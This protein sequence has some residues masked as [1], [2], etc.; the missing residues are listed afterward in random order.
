MNRRTLVMIISVAILAVFAVAVFLYS[1]TT[2]P[3]PPPMP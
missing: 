1:Q 2:P 3:Q